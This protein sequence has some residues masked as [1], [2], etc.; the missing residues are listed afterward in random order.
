MPWKR[1]SQRRKASS[2]AD[3]VYVA[4]EVAKAPCER[5]WE[6]EIVINKCANVILARVVEWF[7]RPKGVIALRLDGVG[8]QEG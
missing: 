8:R 3:G 7:E 1:K 2:Q 5:I 6:R 4:L